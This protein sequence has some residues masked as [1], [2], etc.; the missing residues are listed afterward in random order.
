MSW[1]PNKHLFKSFVHSVTPDCQVNLKKTTGLKP[2]GSFLYAKLQV[3]RKK[4]LEVPVR[5]QICKVTVL[6]W[7]GNRVVNE[8]L[9]KGCMDYSVGNVKEA[10]K[11][12]E[13]FQIVAYND[14]QALI[15]AAAC[16]IAL[17][18]YENALNILEK[19]AEIEPFNEI[20]LYNKALAHAH[21]G[22]YNKT[23]QDLNKIKEFYSNFNEDCNNLRTFAILQSGKASSA[24]KDTESASGYIQR[25]PTRFNQPISNKNLLRPHKQ[26]SSYSSKD[27]FDFLTLIPNSEKPK[28][29]FSQSPQKPEN[30]K[31]LN[32]FYS[33][34]KIVSKNSAFKSFTHIVK[35]NLTSGAKEAK[36]IQE[37]NN[38][39][40]DK[41]RNEQP[42][43]YQR[44]LSIS[45]NLNKEL[46]I[47]EKSNENEEKIRRIKTKATE[48]FE[49]VVANTD[50]LKL[51]LDSCGVNEQDLKF[52]IDEFSLMSEYRN[53][54]KIDQVLMKLDF[55]QKYGQEIRHPIYR[56]SAIKRFE[57]NTI[58]FNQ[59]DIG[60][61]LYIII[62][63]S[64]NVIKSSQDFRNHS[65][66]VSSIY[67]GQHFGDV[68]LLNSL[69]SNPFSSRTATILTSENCHFLVVPKSE[70]QG[71]LLNLQLTTLQE[72]TIFLSELKF[73]EGVDPSLLIPLACNLHEEVFGVKDPVFHKGFVPT[74]VIIIYKGQAKL[75]AEGYAKEDRK[76]VNPGYGLRGIK[77]KLGQ[78]LENKRRR[79]FNSCEG[80]DDK[81]CS[82]EKIEFQTLFT[83]D[84]CGGRALYCNEILP[85]KLSLISDAPDTQI[86]TIT[87][88][89]MFYIPESIKNPMKSILKQCSEPDCPKDIDSKTMDKYF[90]DWGKYKKGLV[91]HIRAQSFHE[92]HKFFS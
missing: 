6:K 25:S 56:F 69:K 61:N 10:L 7:E 80:L 32:K 38:S 54:K 82:M 88:E 17:K 86:L 83:G 42:G 49:K 60:D 74:G 81:V 34:Q 39:V 66:I 37:K 89:H 77:N 18:Q 24:L 30:S 65:V 92:R 59:G 21:L 36:K 87:T 57:P 79:G 85:C 5:P 4:Q 75:I 20:L 78:T 35:K 19:I 33:N 91:E 43:L 12:F 52:L 2:R 44:D 73:F 70:Y 67:S 28:K 58:V 41:I 31:K 62:Q 23:L 11:C 8:M 84:F 16:K 29:L 90:S 1:S 40:K 47:E 9:V 22:N 51:E 72:K 55:F 48:Y 68:A 64:V 53:M 14:Y 50:L 27:N 13:S 15:N 63:G 71:L 45:N 26:I 46:E 3:L 76:K